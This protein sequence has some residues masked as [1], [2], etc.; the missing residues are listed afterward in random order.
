MGPA[1]NPISE[2]KA[3][4]ASAKDF[5]SGAAKPKPEERLLP[6]GGQKASIKEGVRAKR[7]RSSEE[8]DD[9]SLVED[10][11]AG[12]STATTDQHPRDHTEAEGSS[13]ED[14]EDLEGVSV[15]EEG[16]EVI[17]TSARKIPKRRRFN[18]DD[19]F[20]FDDVEGGKVTLVNTEEPIPLDFDDGDGGHAVHITRSVLVTFFQKLTAWRRNTNHTGPEGTEYRNNVFLSPDVRGW[21]ANMAGDP[22]SNSS[23]KEWRTFTDQELRQ[24]I[25]EWLTVKAGQGSFT[26]VGGQAAIP[27]I[28]DDLWADRLTH[29]LTNDAAVNM[30]QLSRLRNTID[31]AFGGATK[32]TWLD[33]P[34]EKKR[35][36]TI[37][38][39]QILLDPR[40]KKP[41]NGQSLPRLESVAIPP[42]LTQSPQMTLCLLTG[43]VI[44]EKTP[45]R[46]GN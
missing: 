34:K 27:K 44:R 17:M 42:D 37:R 20:D 22:H 36:W 13:E 30:R 11:I 7:P 40:V 25:E 14:P 31:D 9:E 29:W 39:L 6:D 45:L 21:L 35:E 43:E 26:K 38:L 18:F 3:S 1:K 23:G 8:E 28:I 19:D 46:P 2:V 15:L 32:A 41:P 33:A 24:K 10:S 5:S 16:E 4:K 12:A